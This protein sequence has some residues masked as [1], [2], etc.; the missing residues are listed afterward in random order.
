MGTD[1]TRQLFAIGSVKGI[2]DIDTKKLLRCLIVRP[3]LENACR[4]WSLYKLKDNLLLETVTPS[5]GPQ[6]GAGEVDGDGQGGRARGTW[7]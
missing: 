1:V 3:Q 2:A 4:I 7:L 6:M 5:P